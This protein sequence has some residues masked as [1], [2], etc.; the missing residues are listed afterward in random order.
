MTGS[1]SGGRLRRNPSLDVLSASL[2]LLLTIFG[3]L[4]LVAGLLDDIAARLKLPGILLVLLLGLLTDNDLSALPNAAPRLLSL[5]QA[6]QITQIAL[7]L[8]LFFGGLTTNWHHMRRVL[9]PAL[10][11]ASLGSLLTALL[12]MLVVI[13]LGALPGTAIDPALPV[14]L[15]VG[16]MVCSTDASAVISL[17]RPLASRLPGRLL[18]LIEFESACNDPVAVVLAGVALAMAAGSDVGSPSMLVIEVARQFL[19]GTLLG[20]IGGTVAQ[21]LLAF[22]GSTKTVSQLPVVSLALLM[23]LVGATQL[24]GG[25]G[26]L[27]AYVAGLVLGNSGEGNQEALVEAHSG[28]AKLAE[29]VL[30]LCL[31][32]VVRA[33]QVVESL[34]WTLVLFVTMQLVRAAVVPLL[35]LRSSFT[36]AEKLLVTMAGLRGAVPIAL[37]IQAAASDVAWGSRMP[38]LALGL[39]LL[40]LTLQGLSLVPAARRL[41]L[42]SVD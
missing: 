31:G 15:F 38:P 13:G 28:F 16:A 19:L 2:A 41:G 40:G 36:R 21:N 11:L 5:P 4:L 18:D 14:A 35:L 39:V 17:L 37:A 7:M 33:D 27:A 42:A 32:L 20:F 8:V 3:A 23:L 12:I 24:L 30:F 9:R 34:G 26:I 1:I 6:E 10:R 29:L 25:S 22:R